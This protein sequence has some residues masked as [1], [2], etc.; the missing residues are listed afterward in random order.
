MVKRPGRKDSRCSAQPSWAAVA[1]QVTLLF[2]HLSVNTLP[3]F[4]QRMKNY[5]FQMNGQIY[6]QKASFMHSILPRRELKSAAL[7]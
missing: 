7:K 1:C 6:V 2:M 4:S 3:T 5:S